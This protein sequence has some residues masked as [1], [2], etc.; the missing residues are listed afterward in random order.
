MKH[1]KGIFLL[2]LGLS[3][4]A[5]TLNEDDPQTTLCQKLTTHLMNE[6]ETNINWGDASRVEKKKEHLLLTVNF[7]KTDAQGSIPMQATCL[8]PY[9][10]EQQG[11]DYEFMPQE[12]LNIPESMT[13][14]G[15]AVRVG[16]L[17]TAIQ[18]VT[19]QSVKDTFNEE[20]IKNKAKEL[21]QNIQ[22]GAKKLDESIQKGS[23]KL[24]ESLEKLGEKLQD[25]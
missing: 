21:E 16:D 25:K 8:Y 3:L 4:S 23:E 5:C 10:N 13:I 2:S 17:H 15:Q 24:G 19:G 7:E 6:S 20:H 22:E 12:Y 1:L 18:K 9:H 14:N 11:E